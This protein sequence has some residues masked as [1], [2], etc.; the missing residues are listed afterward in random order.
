MDHLLGAFGDDDDHN[1]KSKGGQK[2]GHN[3]GGGVPTLDSNFGGMS[4]GGIWDS[5]DEKPSKKAD[6]S[7]KKKNPN[8]KNGQVEEFK[9][10][11]KN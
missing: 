6:K 9:D 8:P 2:D 4:G 3:S 7:N 11:R 10:S 1:H 5:D